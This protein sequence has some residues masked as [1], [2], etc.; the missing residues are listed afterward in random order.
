MI[1]SKH[2]FINWIIISFSIVLFS[3]SCKKAPNNSEGKTDEDKRTVYKI[4][5]NVEKGPFVKGSSLFAFELDESYNQTGRSFR[6]ELVDDKGRFNFDDIQLTHKYVQLS[7]QGG[8]YYDEVLGKLSTSP[9]TLNAIVSLDKP[10]ES[11]NINVLTHLEQKRALFLIKQKGYSFEDAKQQAQK[12]IYDAFYIKDITAQSAETL[13]LI[14]NSNNSS[15][16]LGISSTLL[17]MAA[18][19]NARLTEL[20]S[21][22]SIDLEDDGVLADQLLWEIETAIQK[23]NPKVINDNLKKRY[24]QL[25]VQLAEFPL[26][27]VFKVE[28]PLDYKP[29]GSPINIDFRDFNYDVSGIKMWFTSAQ[30]RYLST[31]ALLAKTAVGNYPSTYNVFYTNNVFPNNEKLLEIYEFAYRSLVELIHI[32]ENAYN[33]PNLEIRNYEQK[34]MSLIAYQYWSITNLWDNPFYY[35]IHNYIPLHLS[36]QVARSNKKEVYSKLISSLEYASNKLENID[37]KYADF[38]KAMIAKLSLEVGDYQR[39]LKYSILLVQSNRYELAKIN[40]I[41]NTKTESIF[42]HNYA[43]GLGST[44]DNE[45][46]HLYAKGTYRHVVRLTEIYLIASEAYYKLNNNQEAIKMLNKL[47]NRDNRAAYSNSTINIHDHIINE[48]KIQMQNEG[49]Y[50]AALRRLSS[51][52]TLNLFKFLPIPFK[53]LNEN[54]LAIQN[55]GY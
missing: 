21:Q 33:S 20:L 25:G 22:I 45:L 24:Q 18:S 15:A 8:Y 46:K 49:V 55:S 44:Y 23:L 42:G 36:K 50:L 9:L 28:L 5:G 29:T 10:E 37:L 43:D 17:I 31:E 38:A 26:A 14:S 7:I 6:T 3:S 12:E 13:S 11:L 40:D 32:S 53:I 30:E 4:H 52:S 34:F 2:C 54:A 51:G 47:T 41:H 19:D 48:Y 27:S 39:A 1:L 35:D 16:L